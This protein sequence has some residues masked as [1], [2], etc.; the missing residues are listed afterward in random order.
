MAA[1]QL[2]YAVNGAVVMTV[3]ELREL[4]EYSTSLPTGTTPGKRWRRARRPWLHADNDEWLLREFGQPYP[5]GHE[6]HGDIPIQWKPILVL[7]VARKW[8]AGVI[9]RRRAMGASG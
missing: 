9:C 1:A 6:Y 7:G 4:P 5:E 2:R 8:P 3:R